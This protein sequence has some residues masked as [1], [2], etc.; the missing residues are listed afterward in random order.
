MTDEKYTFISD[1]REKKVTGYSAMRRRTHA[2]KAEGCD[3]LPTT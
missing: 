3:S 1:V 2:G